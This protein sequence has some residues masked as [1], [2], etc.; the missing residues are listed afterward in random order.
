VRGALIFGLLSATVAGVTMAATLAIGH[1]L[2]H[3]WLLVVGVAAAFGV[4]GLA[5]ASVGHLLM[6]AKPQ[7]NR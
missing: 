4:V 1:E 2:G 6:R 5:L 3:G 7:P